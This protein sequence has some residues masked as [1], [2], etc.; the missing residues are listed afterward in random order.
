MDSESEG[1]GESIVDLIWSEV[2]STS[3]VTDT[4]SAPGPDLLSLA[5]NSLD[6]E[7]Q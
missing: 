1:V 2:L 3:M 5:A 6:S 7:L 4:I